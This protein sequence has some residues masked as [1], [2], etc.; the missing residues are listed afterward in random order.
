[1]AAVN[2]VLAS[3]RGTVQHAST[4]YTASWGPCI[5]RMVSNVA[6]TYSAVTMMMAT[7]VMVMM[8]TTT[9]RRR[10]ICVRSPLVAAVGVVEQ[11]IL[12]RLRV[13][14]EIVVEFGL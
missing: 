3:T 5:V 13:R 12:V 4:A 1:M 14:V 10:R 2:G 11:G 7:V 6:V 9:T 8:L